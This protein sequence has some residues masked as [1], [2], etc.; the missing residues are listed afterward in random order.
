MHSWFATFLTNLALW[1]IKANFVYRTGGQYFME[2]VIGLSPACFSFLATIT[3]SSKFHC[4]S[5]LK[6]DIDKNC[7]FT[8]L[9]FHFFIFSPKFF[10]G[11]LQFLCL[12]VYGL[13]KFL[14]LSTK[15]TKKF[16]VIWEITSQ[17]LIKEL[18]SMWHIWM[19]APA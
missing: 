9:G 11:I 10:Q 13:I 7:P 14:Y 3:G 1:V 15:K 8:S 17:F 5:V 16:S 4:K 18:S 2:Q 6:T 19:N 12:K